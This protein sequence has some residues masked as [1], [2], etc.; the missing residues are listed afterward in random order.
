MR[1]AA[2]FLLRA[3]LTARLCRNFDVI[4]AAGGL[5]R[6]GAVF[7][8]PGE[9]KFDCLAKNRLRLFDWGTHFFNRVGS[10]NPTLLK[11]RKRIA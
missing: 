2:P 3:G 11:Q 10:C 7:T 6:L 9:M 1:G 8:E 4:D 5:G